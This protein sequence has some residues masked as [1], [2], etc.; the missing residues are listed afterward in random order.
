M[1]YGQGYGNWQKY[2]GF[3]ARKPFG[4]MP[5]NYPATS[6][7]PPSSVPV[8]DAIPTQANTPVGQL[9]SQYQESFGSNSGGQFGS[10]EDAVK[11]EEHNY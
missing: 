6:V 1:S 2:A 3:N 4:S 5:E 10:I 7:A 11:A 9:G 8:V